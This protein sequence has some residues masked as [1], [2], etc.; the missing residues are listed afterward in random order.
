MELVELHVLQRNST[1][2]GDGDAVARQRVGVGCDVPDATKSAGGEDGRLG[3]EGVK[4]AAVDV[5]RGHAGHLPRVVDEQIDHL[6]LIEEHD[7]VL[8]ALLI[9]GL[10]DHVARAVGGVTG[11]AHR[12]LGRV[13]GVAAERALRDP[14]IGRAIKRQPHMLQLVDHADR[15][16]TEDL[17]GV[18]IGQVVGA[19]DGIEDVP[20]GMVF[21]HV[22]QRRADAAL[23]RAG[24]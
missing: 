18:L 23:G 1:A 8:D 19:L 3:M 14:A 20:L 13:V 12:L 21:F 22:A 11:P 16:V 9:H 4:L 5:E 24:V 7:V 10:Q 15:L 2:I 6:I 17:H